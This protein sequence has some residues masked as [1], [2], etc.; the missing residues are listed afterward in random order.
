MKV[1][2]DDYT[3]DWKLYEDGKRFNNQLPNS[4]YDVITTNWEFYNGNQYFNATGLSNDFPKPVFNIIKRVIQFFI[5]SMTTS[6]ITGGYEPLMMREDDLTD[7][8]N[9][10]AKVASAELKNFFDRIKADMLA[11]D[12]LLDA[13]VTGDMSIHMYF[14]RTARPYGDMFDI[15]GEICLETI[16]G[17]NI[18]LGNPNSRTIKKQPYILIYGRDTVENLKAEINFHQKL[19]NIDQ[20][21]VTPDSD[22]EEQSSEAG[23]VEMESDDFGKVGYVLVYRMKKNKMGKQTVFVSKSLNNQVIYDNV[24]TGYT[25]YPVSFNNWEHQKNQYHG[26]ALVTDVVPNQIFINR[27]FAMA[28]FHLQNAAFPK[29][30]YDADMI[31]GWSNAVASSI[32]IKRRNPGE[33]LS[34]VAMYLQ[35]ATMSPQITQLID[36]A[37]AYTKEMLGAND[38][39]LGN[40]NPEQASGAA[41]S[42]TAQ[43]SGVPLENPKSN[44]YE[45]FDDIACI[46]ADMASVNYGSR[47]VKV[48]IPELGEQIVEFDFGKLANMQYNVKVDVGATTQWSEVRQAQQLDNLLM[49][50]RIDFLSYLEALPLTYQLPNQ[51]EI[52]AKEKEKVAMMEQQQAM[53]Q[54]TMQPQ[55]SPM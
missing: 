27:M 34:N 31:S 10:T 19:K 49:A 39:L 36:M 32:G 53:A 55:V 9:M 46:F 25:R 14:D 40:I 16:D 45:M 52:V 5:S 4:Y 1:N 29:L 22:T 38:A 43:Q 33:S 2:K 11:K 20:L 17:N 54:Q 51:A 8:T 13:A 28:M 50:Q 21:I 44:L 35:P 37:I 47:P 30:V 26:R 3:K 24:D 42:V 41:I 12:L 18:Y 6:T 23:K 48:D 15:D 7:I